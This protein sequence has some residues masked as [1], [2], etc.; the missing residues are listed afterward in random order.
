MLKKVQGL[1]KGIRNNEYALASLWYVVASVIGQGMVLLSSGLFT[2]MMSKADYGMVST[3]STW[4]LIVNAFICLNLFITIRN[5][6]VDF[7]DDFDQFNSSIMLLGIIVGGTLTIIASIIAYCIGK[8]LLMLQVGFVCLQ[9][10]GLNLV[11]MKLTIQAMRVQYKK[12]FWLLILPNFFHIVLS[13]VLIKVFPEDMYIAKIAGNAIGLLVFGIIAAVSIAHLSSPKIIAKYWKYAMNISVPAIFHTLSD[14]LL[15]QCDRLMLTAMAGPTETAEYSIIYNVG[16]IIVIVYQAINGAWVPWFF[17]KLAENSKEIIRKYQKGYLF[18]FTVLTCAVMTVSPEL[19]K[20]IS[21]KSYW[22]GISYVAPI[23][24]ASYFIFLYSFFTSFLL[25]KKRTRIV[26]VNTMIVAALNIGLNYLYIPKYGPIGA[27]I[28]TLISYVVLFVLHL[29]SVIKD[30]RLF[31]AF[32][33]IALSC[34][35]VII[36]GGLFGFLKEIIWARYLL[37]IVYCTLI[38]LLSGRRIL[39][40]IRSKQ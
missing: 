29:I 12:R 36:Y 28:A 15:M 9:S 2:R 3:Y 14:L 38:Y 19:V 34:L 25:F 10:I 17:G 40:D 24:V 30:G 32:G 31:F 4:A 1:L 22:G 35:L 5:A 7:K 18:A 27:V 33:H 37:F 20:I 21:A 23:I 11:N 13:I 6:Y 8:E 39:K 26:A 16:S